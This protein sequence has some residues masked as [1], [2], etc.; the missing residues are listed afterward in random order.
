MTRKKSTDYIRQ[1]RKNR[2][3]REL[4]HDPYMSKLK[5]REPTVCPKCNAVFHKGRWAWSDIPSQA[6][7]EMCPACHRINDK[8]PAGFLN[9]SGS[10]LK[11]H[12][13]EIL[14]LV[15]NF[16]NIEKQEHPLKRI[17]NIQ[18]VEDGLLVTF[19]DPHLTRGAGEAIHHAYEGEL[20]FKYS[21]G[22]YI[23]R[24]NWKR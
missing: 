17:M 16:E 1:D 20:D 24:V 10:F 15:H 18:E 2:L 14:N 21:K 23:L 7:K 12:R 9:L 3:L 19:T 22:E 8:V 11:D 4:V 5:L 6:H 13:T